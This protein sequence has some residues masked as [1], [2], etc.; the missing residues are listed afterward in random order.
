MITSTSIFAPAL[1]FDATRR[2][3]RDGA[4]FQRHVGPLQRRKIIVGNQDTLATD[5]VIRCQ[6]FPQRC[7]GNL[8]V[9]MVE[10]HARESVAAGR[11]PAKGLPSEKIRVLVKQIAIQHR[12]VRR[13]NNERFLFFGNRAVESRHDPVGGAL[14]DRE[15]FTSFAISGMICTA[16]AADPITATRLP[17]SCT[18]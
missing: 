7:I 3:A 1:V 14:K 13:R 12:N 4:G 18:E 5:R 2:D 11:R 10:G 6:F 17:A 16:L 8:L 9:Q 15:I